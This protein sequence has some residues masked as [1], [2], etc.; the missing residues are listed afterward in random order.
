MQWFKRAPGTPWRVSELPKAPPEDVPMAFQMIP[1]QNDRGSLSA[2]V[3]FTAYT[4]SLPTEFVVVF[5]DG[6]AWFYTT[7]EP[8]FSWEPGHWYKVTMSNEEI[9][10]YHEQGAIVL[11]SV[12]SRSKTH[13]RERLE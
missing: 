8:F 3:D 4:G 6:R 7:L 12:V 10:S 11:R 2:Q 9:E 13:G 5:D 1:T